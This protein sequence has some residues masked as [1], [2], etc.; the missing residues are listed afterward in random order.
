MSIKDKEYT[1]TKLLAFHGSQEIKDKYMELMERSFSW[2]NGS[3]FCVETPL[4]VAA[5]FP[6]Q[7][8]I[9]VWLGKMIE[10]V[11]THYGTGKTQAFVCLSLKSISVGADLSDILRQYAI[12]RLGF[13]L[14]LVRK[15]N[16]PYTGNCCEAISAVKL[17]HENGRPESTK[18]VVKE[19]AESVA[20]L[21]SSSEFGMKERLPALTYSAMLSMT[22][23][24][25]FQSLLWFYIHT[26][27]EW[28]IETLVKLLSQ[29]PVHEELNA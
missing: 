19:F 20:H 4:L 21:A 22:E 15:T 2:R 1:M 10:N 23:E 26:A 7:L 13:S 17:W 18:Q 8:G 25:Y 14:E 5:Q 16:Y 9:P 29:A 24:P 3:S 28:N 12:A 6:E 11:R 27:F